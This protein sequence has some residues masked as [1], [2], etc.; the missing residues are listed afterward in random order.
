MK[1]ILLLVTFGFALTKLQS[2]YYYN[3]VLLT[4]QTSEKQAKSAIAK[5]YSIDFLS[6]DG[7]GQPI[8]GMKSEQKYKKDYSESNTITRLP[9]G[10]TSYSRS[11]FDKKFRLLQ[12]VDSSED[13]RNST[14][15]EYDLQGNLQKVKTSNQSEGGFVMTEEHL[16]IYDKNGHPVSMTK[17]KN[18]KD[19]I[20]V[21]FVLDEKGN[22]VEE[23]STR[24]GQ[25]LPSVYYYYDGLGKLTDVVRYNKAAKKLLPDYV[26][27]YDEKG[28]MG[29]MI[30][31]PEGSN[32]YQKWYYSYDEDNLKQLE[33]CYSKSKQLIGKIEYQYK[34]YE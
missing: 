30:V 7:E 34:Y 18:G 23:N 17:I 22:V 27:E 33:I 25:A 15:Y 20:L 26:F 5:V 16:W 21:V 6:F 29:S 28:R 1:K 12:Q 31:V 10:G 4:S 13:H 19:S 32:D 24:K 9:I 2:Q 8:D 14:Q 3:D 11:N